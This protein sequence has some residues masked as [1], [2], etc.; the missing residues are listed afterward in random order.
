[1]NHNTMEF[2]KGK[3]GQITNIIYDFLFS[4]HFWEMC[5]KIDLTILAV[6]GCF[7]KQFCSLG[8]EDTQVML[9]TKFEIL[10]GFS[11][12]FLDKNSLNLEDAL[13]S[14]GMFVGRIKR[15]GLTIFHYN[16]HPKNGV[17][18]RS[19]KNTPGGE[20]SALWWQKSLI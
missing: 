11:N 8:F 13:L 5:R 16:S 18:W 3:G 9:V 12:N 15:F 14:I 10:L 1:M 6:S 2:C 17:I 7:Q 20:V 4:P 19:L